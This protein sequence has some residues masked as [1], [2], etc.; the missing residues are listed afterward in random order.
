MRCKVSVKFKGITTFVNGKKS[1][2]LVMAIEKPD[3][4]KKE[5][6]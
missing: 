6:E 4:A 3:N 1:F 5:I 2:E